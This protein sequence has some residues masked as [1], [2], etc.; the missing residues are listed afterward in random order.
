MSKYRSFKLIRV[1]LVYIT[2]TIIFYFIGPIDWRTPNVTKLL[3]FLAACLF[4]LFFGFSFFYSRIRSTNQIKLQTYRRYSI[5]ESVLI[6]GICWML[7]L[8]LIINTLYFIRCL[9]SN[10]VSISNIITWILNPSTQ[11]NNKFGSISS[12]LFSRIVAALTTFSS[13]FLW[14][15]IPFGILF[16]RKLPLKVKILVVF[17]IIIELLRW[18]ALGTNKGI[19]D[20]II[21]FL[22]LFLYKRFEQFD[23]NGIRKMVLSKQVKKI[24][25]LILAVLLIVMGLTYFTANI[26]GRIDNNYV[27]FLNNLNGHQLKDNSLLT[28]LF[29]FMTSTLVYAHSYITQGYYGLSLCMEVDDFTPMFGIG[30]SPFLIENFNEMIS[31]NLNDST[32]IYKASQ[33]GWNPNSCWHTAFAWFANDVSFIGVPFVMFIIGY[34]FAFVVFNLIEEKNKMFFPMFCLLIQLFF[35]I[36]MNNQ[37]FS[38]P[39]SFMGFVGMNLNF[40]CL[41][42]SIF[43]SKKVSFVYNKS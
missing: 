38:N 7:L 15:A 28:S 43:K 19:I 16:F 12:S 2:A 25:A 32:Y 27:Y 36:S 29:P 22:C 39:F 24:I 4:M 41:R 18:L 31:G 17:N 9:G 21:L 10:T 5:N 20:I 42:H 1:V 34:Y 30:H 13:L 33:F 35:Y 14:P 23:S 37:I 6:N 40:F 26:S 3:L 8:N 11:Y